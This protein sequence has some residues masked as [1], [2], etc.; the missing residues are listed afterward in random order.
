VS[1]IVAGTI[2]APPGAL[3]TLRP[4][5]RAMARASRAEAGCEVYSYAEDVLDPGLIRVFEVWSDRAALSAHFNTP[6]LAAWRAV[7][8]SLGVG[9]RQLTAYEI[10]ACEPL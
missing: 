6:H 3:A 8:P 7:W 10:H 5:M 9:E 2:R 4:H 1:V